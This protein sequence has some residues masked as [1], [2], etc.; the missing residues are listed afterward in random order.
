MDRCLGTFYCSSCIESNSADIHQNEGSSIAGSDSNTVPTAISLIIRSFRHA[1][2]VHQH[3]QKALS[4]GA[5]Q[6]QIGTCHRLATR[7]H[8]DTPSSTR[9]QRG[10]ARVGRCSCRRLRPVTVTAAATSTKEPSLQVFDIA[11]RTCSDVATLQSP[12]LAFVGQPF[13]DS[14]Q[15]HRVS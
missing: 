9:S 15:Q 13:S 11:W 3:N 6:T 4:V 1:F 7:Y 10:Y 12:R 5:M 8:I 2:T 14:G